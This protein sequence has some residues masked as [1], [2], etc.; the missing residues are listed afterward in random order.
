MGRASSLP[1]VGVPFIESRAVGRDGEDPVGNGVAHARGGE[2][3]SAHERQAAWRRSQVVET[4]QRQQTF[5]LTNRF[6]ALTIEP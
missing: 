4:R 6:R 5:D 1:A 2:D 3:L